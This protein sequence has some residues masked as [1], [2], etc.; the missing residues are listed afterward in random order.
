MV[1]SFFGFGGLQLSQT[2]GL[3]HQ[4]PFIAKH[5]VDYQKDLWRYC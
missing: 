2:T 5:Q 4:G 3:I 1:F